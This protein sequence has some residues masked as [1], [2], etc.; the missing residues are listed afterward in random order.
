MVETARRMGKK[1]VALITDMDQP[2]GRF[3]AIRTK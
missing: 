3:A 1:A 2:L